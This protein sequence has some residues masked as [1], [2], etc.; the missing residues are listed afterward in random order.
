MADAEA[1]KTVFSH[2]VHHVFIQARHAPGTMKQEATEKTT[3]TL[4]ASLYHKLRSQA[5]KQGLS[6]P[7]FIQ[8]HIQ[9]EPSKPAPLAQLS[10]KQLI[11]QTTP[12][13]T[14]PDSRLD[15]FS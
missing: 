5:Y 9:L 8:E 3:I 15:F 12:K 10:L 14:N 7:E 2:N 6:L 1:Q 13:S 4:P 11:K